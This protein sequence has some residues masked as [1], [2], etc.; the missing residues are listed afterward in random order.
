MQEEFITHIDNT[1]IQELINSRRKEYLLTPLRI[2]EDYNNENKNIDEYNGRQLLEMIQNANDESDTFKAKKVFI[3]LGEHSLLIANNGNA[4][5]LGGV[6]SLVYSDLSP[7]TMEKNKVGKK[8]LGFR[9]ILNWSKEIYIASY[10]LHLKFSQK[11]AEDFLASLLEEKPEIKQTLERKTKKKIPISVLRCPFLETDISKKKAQVYDTVIELILKDDDSIFSSINK[12]IEKDITPEILIF[13]NKLEEIEVQ[14]PDS[15]FQLTKR[16]NRAENRINITRTDYLDPE[17]NQEWEWNILEDKGILEGVEET[18][19]YELKIAYNPD[20]EVSFNKLFSFF[21]TEVDFPYPVIA[22]GSFELKSDRNNLS[23]D[24][25]NFNIQLIEKLA[26][27]LVDCAIELTKSVES[28][29]DAL[30]LLI[31]SGN[32]YSSLFEDPWLFDDLIKDHINK[33]PIFPTISNTFIT[34]ENDF[35]FYE[36]PID[37]LIPETHYSNFSTLLKSTIDENIIDYFNNEYEGLRYKDE[38]FTKKLNRIIDEGYFEIGDKVKWIDKLSSNVKKFYDSDKPTLPNLLVNH[39]ERVIRTGKDEIIL[40][41]KGNVYDLP[42]EL[43]LQFVDRAFTEK[44]KEQISGDI[45]DLSNRLR[46]FGVDEYSMTVVARK[47]I[48]ASH[49]RLEKTEDKFAIVRAMHSVLFNIYD[50]MK[51]EEKKVFFQNLPSP[52][53]FS[54]ENKLKPA[55]KLYFSKVYD[56]GFLCSHLLNSI[57]EDVFIGS[58]KANGLDVLIENTQHI[59]LEKYLKWIGV[60]DLPRRNFFVNDNIPNKAQYVGHIFDGLTYPYSLPDDPKTFETRQ[61]INQ[62]YSHEVEVLWFDFLED[63][64]ANASI[65]YI[66]TWFIRDRE[67]NNCIILDNEHEKAEFYFLFGNVRNYRYIDDNDVRSYLLYRLHNSEFIPIEDGRKAKPTE[68]VSNSGSLSPLVYTPQ[69]NFES[70]IFNRFN[71]KEDQINLLLNRLGVKESFK[72]LSLSV[73]YNLLNEH[74]KYFDKSGRS[75]TILYSAIID[76]TTNYAKD[77]NWAINERAEYLKNGL[78]LCTVNGENKYVPINDATYVL[79]PNHSQDLL[80]K[81]NVAKIRQRVGNNRIKELFGIE[82]M[83]YIEFKVK[84]AEYNSEL[85]KTF[86]SELNQLKPLLFIYRYQKN[87]TET[88]KKKELGSLKQLK[89][90]ICYSTDVEFTLNDKTQSLDLK[91]NEYVFEKK[92]QTYFIQVNKNQLSYD[93]LKQDYRFTETLS[94]I[95]CGAITVTENRKD[96]MLIIAQHQSKWKE[97][98]TR[99]FPDF[100]NLESEVMKNFDGVLTSKQL[101]WKSIL[102]AINMYSDNANLDEEKVIYQSLKSLVNWDNYFDINRSLNYLEL[103]NHNNFGSI[104]ALFLALK[105]DINDFNKYSK[106]KLDFEEYYFNL[107]KQVHH[108][109]LKIYKSI[110]FSK[111]YSE[112]FVFDIE[113]FENYDLEQINIPNSVFVDIKKLYTETL[114]TT[115]I[116]L[117]SSQGVT[118]KIIDVEEVF[119]SNLKK[120][121]KKLQSENILDKELLLSLQYEEKF[122][123]YLYFWKIEDLIKSYKTNY[124]DSDAKRRTVKLTTE[125]EEID[126]TDDEKLLEQIEANV[127]DIGLKIQVYKPKKGE[128]TKSKTKP[129]TKG[130]SK[131]GLKPSGISKSDIGFIGEKYAYELLQKQFDEVIWKSEYAIR[132]GFSGGKD[133]YGFD[134]ECRKGDDVRYIEVKATTTSANNFYVSKNEVQIGHTHFNNY[135]ILLISNLLTEDIEAKYLKN[136]FQYKKEN[137]FFDNPSFL[138]ETDGYK[139]KFK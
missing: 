32:Q 60:A 45:R 132:A 103:S 43:E 69:I 62:T 98:M 126:I 24:K 29:Y 48:S 23:Q 95:I 135:D 35:K 111:G 37:F 6:E 127:K 77:F 16:N 99:E 80:A 52:L 47:V 81:L 57:K 83:D 78:V 87:L 137:T 40:P 114:I 2:V 79:N 33:A 92:S 82:P 12:Q 4:F 93:S 34:L 44:L 41:P 17:N 59:K 19:H 28:N 54:Q 138:V 72:D 39:K 51:E 18:K 30:K 125:G 25:N 88:Q 14:T 102:K 117:E 70:D 107:L 20:E 55:N 64:L 31:P 121:K 67:I 104:K 122:C 75:A 123:N 86:Q 76:A 109:Y 1:S 66:I 61:E 5:S 101:F 96:F 113:S 46:V 21:R 133:G 90:K 8:G 53:L 85:N 15:H 100:A 106:D 134:F 91:R 112:S 11:H 108:N 105:I 58:R 129:K 116:D 136:I 71:I 10:S 63:I 38:E 128:V 131:N 119:R 56:S 73:M 49:Q 74:Q 22:H 3:K 65:E 7:K 89:V 27:L 130:Q 118:K 36:E 94:D 115:Y 50:G 139:I 42:D 120:F 97:I 84:K 68:C 26:K 13:L 9:S 110:L 124:L